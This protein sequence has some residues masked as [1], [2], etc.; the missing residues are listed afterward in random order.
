MI[1]KR[2]GYCCV[3]YNVVIVKPSRVSEDVNFDDITNFEHK[4]CNIV[5]PHLRFTNVA[6]C[7]IHSYHW[8]RKTP[9]FEF[10]QIEFGNDYCRIG[11]Y[12]TDNFQNYQNFKNHMEAK[13]GDKKKA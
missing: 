3:E 10:T 12:I 7:Q 6:E 4:P 5:C 8:Y 11:E 2:C 9:C 13:D 1:C